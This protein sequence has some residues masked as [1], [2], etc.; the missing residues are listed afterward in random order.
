MKKLVHECIEALKP[1]AELV[2]AHKNY[3]GDPTLLV[4]AHDH[5]S[6]LAISLHDCR[7][8]HHTR[9]ELQNRL[10]RYDGAYSS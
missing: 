3:W 9:I 5:E 7:I 4:L 8:A 10:E 1:F 2:V 6:G